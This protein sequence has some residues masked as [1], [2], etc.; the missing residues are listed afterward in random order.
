MHR[1]VSKQFGSKKAVGLDLLTYNAQTIVLTDNIEALSP[2]VRIAADATVT[3]EKPTARHLNAVR[4]LALRPCLDATTAEAVA[5]ED[6]GHDRGAGL[7][8][9]TC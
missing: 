2:S 4:K 7:P 1:V 5:G 3:V 6:W 9:L 8:I